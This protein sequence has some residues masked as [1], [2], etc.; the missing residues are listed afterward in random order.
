MALSLGASTAI[1][2]PRCG[3]LALTAAQLAALAAPLMRRLGPPLAR[4]AAETFLTWKSW[5]ALA[6]N[7]AMAQ[8]THA[9]HTSTPNIQIY[10]HATA[11]TL[12]PQ[13]KR[14][15]F[16]LGVHNSR[17]CIVACRPALFDPGSGPSQQEPAVGVDRFAPPP[18]RVAE[19]VLVGGTLPHVDIPR[20][21]LPATQQH[22]CCMC[23]RRSLTTTPA[24]LQHP[25]PGSLL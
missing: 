23:T 16:S 14:P 17:P 13:L 25:V 7:E 22:C 19:V 4:V 10:C 1:S 15:N 3:D 9:S 20:T 24:D 6:S 8:P 11:R 18:R 5:C 2:T 21:R 12:Q